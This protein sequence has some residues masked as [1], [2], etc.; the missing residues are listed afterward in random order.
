MAFQT[1]VKPGLFFPPL[2][3][4]LPLGEL[5]AT[6]K[7]L[8]HLSWRPGCTSVS[9]RMERVCVCVGGREGDENRWSGLERFW[10][11]KNVWG[12]GGERRGEKLEKR[13]NKKVKIGRRL[14]MF[15]PTILK[16]IEKTRRKKAKTPTLSWQPVK[17]RQSHWER[18]RAGKGRRERDWGREREK[19]KRSKHEFELEARKFPTGESGDFPIITSKETLV[20]PALPSLSASSALMRCCRPRSLKRQLQLH[21]SALYEAWCSLQSVENQQGNVLGGS[22]MSNTKHSFRMIY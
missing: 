5:C 21:D 3:D 17:A 7:T 22:W 19:K 13:G 18:E 20:S 15:V 12:G 6:S 14:T 8:H 4:F 11:K 9:G 2:H 1:S 16:L 10:R